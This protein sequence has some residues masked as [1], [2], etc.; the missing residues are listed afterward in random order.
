MQFIPKPKRFKPLAPRFLE[1]EYGIEF[2]K[3]EFQILSE[4]NQAK[5][6]NYPTISGRVITNPRLGSTQFLLIPALHLIQDFVICECPPSMVVPASGSY[7]TVKGKKKCFQD[8]CKIMVEDIIPAKFEAPKPEIGFKDFQELLFLQWNGID[9]P[10]RELLGF[11][12]VSCPPLFALRQVGGLNLSLY[13]GTGMGL[14]KKILRYFRNVIP[15]EIIK[16]K[17]SVIDIPTISIRIRV[18]SFPWSF[19]TSDV[20]R[21][22]NPQL[23]EFLHN[24]KSRKFS[25]ISVGLGTDKSAPLSLYEQP[26]TAVDQPA[27]L[28]S[29]TEKRPLKIDPPFEITKYIIT[30][31]LWHPTIGESQEDINVILEEASS[32]L[33]RLAENFD[34]PHLIRR[35]A[36]FDP[37]YYGKPQSILRIALASARAQCKDKIDSNWVM[38]VFY[39][40]YLENMKTI[41]E[42]WEDLITSK[43]VELVSITNELDRQLL[44]FITNNETKETGVG[45]H[46]IQE[47]FFNRNDFELR[48]AL[49]RLQKSGKIYE[50][51]PDVFR[52]VPL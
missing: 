30:S 49:E 44:K 51:K 40:Y 1:R 25:E 15:S 14:S 6:A 12:F 5:K 46:L 32:K 10:L 47:H 37:N 27:I 3:W 9:S 29:S 24:R 17:S 4:F 7:V 43:G 48:R 45:F 50:I 26:L 19:K 11:E 8:H 21:Q 34:V 35:Y 31:H 28:P 38:Q 13:D 16:G 52:S 22:L 18:P 20:D 2:N 23:L 39:N 33:I 41:F 36:L 42:S